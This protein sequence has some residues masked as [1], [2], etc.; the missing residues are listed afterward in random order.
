MNHDLDTLWWYA[1]RAT[2]ITAW[3]LAALSVYWGLLASTR[4]ARGRWRAAWVVDLHRHLGGLTF[5]FVVL[6]IGALQADMTEPHIKLAAVF[7]PMASSWRPAAVTWG[8]MALYLLA[9]VEVTSLLMHRIPRRMWWSVH[10]SS[11]VIF[12]LANIHA[13]TAGTDHANPAIQW[14]CLVQLSVLAFLGTYRL[15][16]ALVGVERPPLSGSAPR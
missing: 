4:Y 15:L 3:W 5:A 8:V 12:G 6:H 14:S 7:V 2:G 1:A 9:A 16:D 10:M 11:L 13:L